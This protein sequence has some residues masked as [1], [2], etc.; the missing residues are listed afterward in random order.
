MDAILRGAFE[1]LAELLAPRRCAGC[2]GET[3]RRTAFCPV[4]FGTLVRASNSD[5]ERLAAFV[6]GGAIA[7]AVRRLK[8]EDRPDL[9]PLLLA[10]F[11][12]LVPQLRGVTLVVPVPLH[13]SRLVERGYNQAALLARPLAGVLG[14]RCAVH[15]L[16]RQTAT[17]RQTE[18]SRQARGA[19]VRDA[20]VA[21]QPGQLAEQAVLVVDDVETTGATLTACRAALLSG[22]ARR[23]QTLVIARAEGVGGG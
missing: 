19:N 8:F 23:V 7:D 21:N 17:A 14:V 4:C 11:G 16:A 10:S 18:L 2:D 3:K 13:P 5:P 12:T 1:L 15:A 6:Y 20:F 22:G 9:A